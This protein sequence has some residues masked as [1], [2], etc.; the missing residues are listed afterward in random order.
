MWIEE[1]ENRIERLNERL[2]PVEVRRLQLDY[3]PV[4]ARRLNTLSDCQR[5]DYLK[6][7]LE[8][9]LDIIEKAEEIKEAQR[10]AYNTR[11]KSIISHFRK[12]HGLKS[13]NYYAA[14]Y[15]NLG[16]IG[17]V[18]A[19]VWFMDQLVLMIAIILMGPVIG[20]ILGSFRDKHNKEDLI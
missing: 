7:D 3:L 8:E 4:V 14:Q 9:A 10:R 15:S 2:L 5:C 17:G 16:L 6:K 13:K 1:I 20:K 18:L 12:E 19:G 11:I